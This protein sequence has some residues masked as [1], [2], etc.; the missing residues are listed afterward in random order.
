MKGVGNSSYDAYGLVVDDNTSVTGTGK[1]IGIGSYRTFSSSNEPQNVTAKGSIDGTETTN[2]EFTWDDMQ[3]TYFYSGTRSAYLELTP[4]GGDPDEEVPIDDDG[5][6]EE[7]EEDEDSKYVNDYAPPVVPVIYDIQKTGD[8]F[9]FKVIAA[10]ANGN[11]PGAQVPVK[12]NEKYS[13]VVT[14]GEDG[15]GFGTIDATGFIGGEAVFSARI[16]GADGNV[17]TPMIVYSDGRV[18]RK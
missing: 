8:T 4:G 2:L 15:V 18:V 16:N 3:R 1:I 11:L 13:T 17:T 12:I 5:D 14:I 9:S 10:N 6:E 7:D